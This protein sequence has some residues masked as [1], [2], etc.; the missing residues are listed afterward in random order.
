MGA[1]VWSE[2]K[3]Q[4]HQDMSSNDEYSS[5]EEDFLDDSLKSEVY[6]GFSDTKI[7]LDDL[8]TIEDTFIGGQP[9][10]LH[11]ESS[12]SAEQVT[13]DNC[14]KKMALLMQAFA[15]L[16][17]KLYD[18][19]IYIFGCKDS[20]RCSRQ[21][22]SIKAIRGVSK[23]PK[24]VAEISGE[25]EAAL[26]KTLDEKL[27]LEEKK[28]LN[29]AV[30]KDIFT[31]SEAANPF[32]NPFGEGSNP[33]GKSLTDS[34]PF[35]KP[36][37]NGTPFESASTSASAVEPKKETESLAQTLK[38]SAPASSKTAVPCGILPQYPGTFVY[39][40]Q[41]RLKKEVT[42]DS[43]LEKYK[44]LIDVDEEEEEAKPRSQGKSRS[45]GGKAKKN[46][47][48]GSSSTTT[49]ANNP[50]NQKIASMLDDKHF[51]AFTNTVK[52]NSGQVLRYN[53]GGRPL[54]Y[55]GRDEIANQFVPELNL[56]APSYNPTSSRQFE[57][58][59]M[60]KTIIDLEQ[61]GPNATVAD[62]L[63]GMS[64][65]TIIVCTDVEDSVSDDALDERHVAYI[66]EYCG[67]QWE[68]STR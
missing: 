1:I 2:K 63:N 29:I 67:V 13:C 36:V 50:A 22:G 57:L 41:E 4:P 58:Q 64:W 23:D 8:P 60:P 44:H 33:F 51:E 26:Q 27:Q 30:T 40:D 62:I 35:G 11:P 42:D 37:G 5:D 7:E 15:P 45:K 19:V 53:L 6:L 24:R 48:D 9:V 3:N 43:E 61:M 59:L 56:A 47:K 12:P 25:Q 21:K 54:L 28:K 17:G 31:N 49:T 10:W 55:S 38:K 18:R 66:Q 20:A 68:E 52:H 32:G 14:G 39:V 46:I 34:N 65:G 16:D